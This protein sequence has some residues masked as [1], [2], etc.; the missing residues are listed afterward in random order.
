MFTVNA[1]FCTF[2]S[3]YHVSKIT[4]NS[5]MSDHSVS[6]MFIFVIIQENLVNINMNPFMQY[7]LASLIFSYSVYNSI[8]GIIRPIKK[9]IQ[10]LN[11]IRFCKVS[12]SYVYTNINLI[13]LLDVSLKH[14]NKANR[15]IYTCFVLKHHRTGTCYGI[16][17]S[18]PK[19]IGTGTVAG[20]C[21][22]D[23]W[24]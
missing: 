8:A 14:D 12:V 20:V 2:F 24:W 19:S 23:V 22:V 18:Q 16:T 15:E 21:R 9:Y 1:L 10:H 6:K 11:F 5:L 7:C 17:H 4:P 3:C 13:F